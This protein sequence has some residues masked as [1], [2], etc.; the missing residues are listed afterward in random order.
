MY[1]DTPKC[2][3]ITPKTYTSKSSHT[4]DTVTR[5]S[6][7]QAHPHSHT[8]CTLG[9][10]T[11]HHQPST[12]LLAE[13]HTSTARELPHPYLISYPSPN[14]TLAEAENF[15]STVLT[16]TGHH[17][18]TEPRSPDSLHLGHLPGH[19]P[20]LTSILHSTIPQTYPK[21]LLRSKAA[22]CIPLGISPKQHRPR[23]LS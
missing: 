12:A 16:L 15:L 7:S 17:P 19:K 21:H 8:Q 2:T 14:P 22:F 18:L 23:S 1:G 9:S 20:R 5:P 3:Q 11:S 6:N 4:H 10:H 13:P